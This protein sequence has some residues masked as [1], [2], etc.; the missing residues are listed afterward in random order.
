MIDALNQRTEYGYD[1][2]GNLTSVKDASNHVTE[3]RYDALNR[4]VDT[5]LPMGQLS[6]VTYDAVGNMASFTNA[7]GETITYEY[8]ALNRLTKKVLPSETFTMTYASIGKLASVTDS[9][10]TT[11][12]SYDARQ[13]LTEQIDP[14]GQ[15]LRYGY[16]AANLRTAITTASGTTTFTYDKYKEL[17]TVTDATGAV[18]TYNYDKAGNLIET[19]LAN[20]VIEKR[21]YDLLNRLTQIESKKD[22]TVIFSAAYTLDNAGMRT[23][24]VEN[25]AG[26]SRTVNYTYDG[27]YRLLSENDGVSGTSYTYSPTGNRLT[28]TSGGVTANYVYDANDR[29]LT[30]GTATF[31]YDSNGNKKTETKDGVTTTYTWDAENRLKATEGGGTSTV[32]DYDYSGIRVSQTVNGVE[33]RFLVDK[34]RN[35]AQVLAEYAPSGTVFA[36]YTYGSDLISQDRN[37]TKSFYVY[38]G[39]G[40][41]RALTDATGNVTDTYNYDAYGNLSSSTG[42][43]VNSYLYAGEQFDKNLGDYYLR[44]RYYSTD[45]GRFTQRDR[46]DGVMNNPLSLNRYGYTHGNPVNGTDPSGMFLLEQAAVNRIIATLA[47]IYFVSYSRGSS[48]S[49]LTGLPQSERPIPPIS[50]AEGLPLQVSIREL[51][52]CAS[53]NDPYCSRTGI[54]TVVYT[55]KDLPGHASHINA[56]QNGQGNTISSDAR[57]PSIFPQYRLPATL[58]Y[59][60]EQPRTFLDRTSHCNQSARDAWTSQFHWISPAC[61]E[62]PFNSSIEGGETRYNMGYVSLQLLDDLESSTQGGL[63]GAFYQRARVNFGDIFGVVTMPNNA[64]ERS[65]WI[66]R[67]GRTERPIGW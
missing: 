28:K 55:A 53:L 41:T 11:T 61:D 24:V 32:Y 56:A 54:P 22:S 65:F 46:F 50:L 57:N 34:N 36:S 45:I 13:R 9:R 48:G 23:K 3:Y 7:N 30:D 25:L 26:Y 27:L 60:S 17:Q 14:D 64:G 19:D 42:T 63:M 29:L 62:Y 52:T 35:Y 49:R 20:G 66:T 10:G 58:H 40:S 38:D 31:T 33:T 15:F 59:G 18:T 5:V 67:E 1:L 37:G 12:Y 44:D 16:N 21:S 51:N 39:L 6:R 4:R 43:T 8:D 47:A 2:A